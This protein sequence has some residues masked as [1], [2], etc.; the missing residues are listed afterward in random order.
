MPRYFKLLIIGLGIPTVFLILYKKG[1]ANDKTSPMIRP[2]SDS[3]NL[4]AF[5]LMIQH[6]EG[7]IGEN[8]Y[9]MFFGGE[10][11]TD[12]SVHPNRAIHKSGITST[13]AGAYQFLFRT[14]SSLKQQLKLSDFSPKNQDVAAIEL[15]RQKGALPDVLAGRI[16]IAIVK[17][18]KIWASLPGAGYGQRELRM[19]ELLRFY[20]RAG[21]TL[22]FS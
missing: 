19:E 20:E 16:S 17:V 13:A 2:Y 15:I 8:A 1:F 18:Q 5:L 3:N 10:L 11:F 21:G 9:R 4:K 6:A 12:Y 22:I 7:T 14:W